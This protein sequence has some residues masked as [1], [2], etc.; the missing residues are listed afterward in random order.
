MELIGAIIAFFLG[1]GWLGLL[2]IIAVGTVV[3]IALGII[4]DAVKSIA[5][6]KQKGEWY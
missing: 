6:K 3:L 2:L 5:G 4:A 1:L